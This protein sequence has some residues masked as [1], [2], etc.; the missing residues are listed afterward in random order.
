MKRLSILK[1]KNKLHPTN[2]LNVYA[3]L[4]LATGM[5]GER[6]KGL[7]DKPVPIFFNWALSGY[8]NLDLDAFITIKSSVNK[9]FVVLNL[10]HGLSSKEFNRLY[11]KD[12]EQLGLKE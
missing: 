4:P 7:K 5:A 10:A 11:G 1:R 2:K 12:I 3:I 9:N 6:E 8:K